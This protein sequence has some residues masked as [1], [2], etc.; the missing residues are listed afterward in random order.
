[1]RHFCKNITYD[2][3]MSEIEKTDIEKAKRKLGARDKRM[4]EFLGFA[5]QF[6]LV[7]ATMTSV[8]QSLVESIISQQLTGKAA[9]TIFRRLCN[10]FGSVSQVRPVDIFRC[11]DD[12]L[13]AIGISRPKIAAIRDLTDFTLDGKLPGCE[14]LQNMKNEDII[15]TLVQIK[16]VGQWTVEMMLIFKLGRVDVISGNDLGLKKG[17]AIIEGTWPNYPTSE[18]M[19]SHAEKYWKP[20]RS[21]ASW[22]LWRAAE[23]LR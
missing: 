6:N 15:N 16:G 13:R 3:S 20:Y 12:E 4:K 22:Y 19:L 21:I 2:K 11:E 17:F 5:P 18:I 7:P 1:M 10:L 8:Y 23:G 14:K 9:F